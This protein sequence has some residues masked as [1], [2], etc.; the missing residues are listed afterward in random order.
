[1]RIEADYDPDRDNFR[2]RGDRLFVFKEAQKAPPRTSTVGG[3]GGGAMIMTIA[4]GSPAEEDD[5]EE[6]RPYEVI[7]YRLPD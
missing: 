6:I 1:M 5:D 2:L 7:C 4:A 3:A